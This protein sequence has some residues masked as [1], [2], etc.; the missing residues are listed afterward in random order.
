MH[1]VARRVVAPVLAQAASLCTRN[2]MT[3]LEITLD[4][5]DRLRELKFS[6]RMCGSAQIP[7]REATSIA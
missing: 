6:S 3:T 2:V 1:M 5:P 4:L 7:A